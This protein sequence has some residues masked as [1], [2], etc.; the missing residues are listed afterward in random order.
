MHCS[1]RHR[2]VTVIIF[3]L[4]WGFF[5]TSFFTDIITDNDWTEP[6]AVIRT[7]IY[8]YTYI[9]YIY[10]YM[11]IHTYYANFDMVGKRMLNTNNSLLSLFYNGCG[12]ITMANNHSHNSHLCMKLSKPHMMTSSNGDI[13]RVTGPLWGEFTGHRWIP[14]TKASDAELWRFLW[15]A[16]EQTV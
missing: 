12:N 4:H 14:L 5:V 10:I 3:P 6:I 2:A 8:T 11:H 16:P 9:I 1:Q 7:Y 13:F 15:S